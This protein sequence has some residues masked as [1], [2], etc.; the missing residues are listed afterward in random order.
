[1]EDDNR[2]LYIISKV[3]FLNFLAFHSLLCLKTN[4]KICLSGV[5]YYNPTGK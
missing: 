1:M 4:K 5:I 3:I 2:I